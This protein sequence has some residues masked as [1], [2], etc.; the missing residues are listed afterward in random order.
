MNAKAPIESSKRPTWV[1]FALFQ[2][3]VAPL[4]FAAIAV[5]GGLMR[6]GYSHFS[7]AI[8]ELTEAGAANKI[9]LD[10][11][12]LVMEIL[13]I[14]FG[15]GFFLVVRKTN[16]WLALSAGSMVLIGILGMFFYRFPMDPMGTPM[17]SDGRMHLVIVSLSAVAAIFAVFF[18]AR[19]WSLVSGRRG[20]ALM[21]YIV[22]FAILLTGVSSIFVGVWG[23]PGI[24][25]WQRVNT[26]AFSIW[27][28]ATA[29]SLLGRLRDYGATAQNQSRNKVV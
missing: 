11:P 10:L 3:I 28:I 25:L 6:P 5:V 2:G 20:I 14:I 15:L 7:Q 19:G 22:L 17:T 23:W 24:G 18:S 21:S 1:V 12:L 27:E 16:L 29:V 4:F 13:T 26:G 8:S 9:Y